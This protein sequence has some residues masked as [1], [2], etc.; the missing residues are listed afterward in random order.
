[1]LMSEMPNFS[2]YSEIWRNSF[3]KQEM[4]TWEENIELNTKLMERSSNL[5]GGGIRSK[6]L[7]IQMLKKNRKNNHN[8]FGNL[9]VKT[10]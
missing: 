5:D 8:E 10:T 1:M 7:A 3:N 9:K 6:F 4:V 2:H